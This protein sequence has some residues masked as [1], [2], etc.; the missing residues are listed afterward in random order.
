M[1]KRVL[2]TGATGQLGAYLVREL[3][4]QG[5]DVRAWAH[6]RPAEVFG[7]PAPAVELTDRDGLAA[8]FR[9]ASGAPRGSRHVRRPARLLGRFPVTCRS[10]REF[11]PDQA[12]SAEGDLP[13]ER[14]KPVS[15][16]TGRNG[17]GVS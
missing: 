17:T 6:T 9:A 13:F 1:G 11:C 10:Q 3:V 8:A 14:L 16:G 5:C 15:H 7:V 2:V 4:A 12:S